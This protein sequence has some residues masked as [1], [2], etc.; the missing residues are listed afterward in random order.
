[1][2]D[3]IAGTLA[4]MG[5]R[6]TFYQPGVLLGDLPPPCPH[7]AIGALREALPVFTDQGF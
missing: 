4:P 3:F 5:R 6:G 1:M 2:G 7:Y